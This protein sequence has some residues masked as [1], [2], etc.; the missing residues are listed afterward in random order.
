LLNN[1]F[2][3]VQQNKDVKT[4]RIVEWRVSE[5]SCEVLAKVEHRA[6]D[7][8]CGSVMVATNFDGNGCGTCR[9]LTADG[10]GRARRDWSGYLRDGASGL[11]FQP[12]RDR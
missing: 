3:I 5:V 7:A 9:Y 12:K 2:N 6:F 4:L 10:F 11:L 1:M 8:H